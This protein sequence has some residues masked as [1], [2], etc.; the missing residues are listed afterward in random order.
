MATDIPHHRLIMTTYFASSASISVIVV[1]T[2]F[3]SIPDGLNGVYQIEF[4]G[5]GRIEILALA[6]RY[7][8][9]W[10]LTVKVLAIFCPELRR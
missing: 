3:V 2:F 1:V 9:V 5:L 7:R 6:L 4:S 8:A 10:R